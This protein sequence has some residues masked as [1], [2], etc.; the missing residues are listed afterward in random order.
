MYCRK[1]LSLLITFTM[2]MSFSLQSNAKMIYMTGVTEEMCN[3]KYWAAKHTDSDKLL[4][5][6]EAINKLNKQF[7]ES[8]SLNINDLKNMSETVNGIDLNST[9]LNAAQSDIDYFTS[10]DAYDADGNLIDSS[11]FTDIL[12]NTQNPNATTEQDVLYGICVNRTVMT[13]LPT[14]KAIKDDFDD[15]DFDN[16]YICNVMV[17]DPFRIE[18][19]SADGKYYWGYSRILTGW[20]PSKDIAIC[21]NKEEWLDAWDMNPDEAFVVYGDKILTE[22]SRNNPEISKRELHLGTILKLAK[23]NE[24]EISDRI[25]NR[26]A[27]N[28]HVVWMPVRNEDGSF[29][30]ELC[31]ISQHTKTH[32]GFLPLTEENIAK[33]AFGSLGN[34]YGWGGMLNSVDCS[35]FN[36]DIYRCFGIFSSRDVKVDFPAKHYNVRISAL[37]EEET[38]GLT[39]QQK[40]ELADK[41]K[42]IILDNVPIGTVVMWSSHEM[43]YLGEVDGKHYVINSVSN[44]V[45]DWDIGVQRIRGVTINCL[46]DT[47]RGNGNS[48]LTAIDDIVIPYIGIDNPLYNYDYTQPKKSEEDNKGDK[49]ESGVIPDNDNDNNKDKS[50][51]D[52]DNIDNKTDNKDSNNKSSNKIK[53]KKSTYSLVQ[54]K[55]RTINLNATTKNG[56]LEYFSNNKN[57]TV[58]EK[59]IVTIKKNFTGNALITIT[60]SDKNHIIAVKDININVKPKKT[61]I[62]KINI[63]NI[64]SKKLKSKKVNRE[65][66]VTTSKV[67]NVTGYELQYS[68]NPKFTANNTFSKQTKSQKITIKKAKASNSYYIRV[69]SYKTIKIGNVSTKLYS[70]WSKTKK[71]KL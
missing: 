68:S 31:L 66:T 46:E 18:S 7:E 19:V 17:N 25:N 53:T 45:N 57:V 34:V 2:I 16:I 43:M 22:E 20:V 44:L 26:S 24:W 48:W 69:R 47:Y 58:N 33:V 55:K 23:E 14:D 42:Q 41:K 50:N 6:A 9:L 67:E 39:A 1:I 13:C 10:W 30:K 36:K 59:G 37:P 29:K 65:F 15:N 49:G 5:D 8:E 60:A 38:E 61:S 52:N 71:I 63:K 21:A 40:L 27:Y 70:S 28:N 11:Y 12:N 62:K 35:G 4:L 56:T 54:G 51:T 64:D 32:E 3:Y